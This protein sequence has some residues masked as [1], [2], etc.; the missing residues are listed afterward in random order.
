MGHRGRSGRAAIAGKCGGVYRPGLSAKSARGAQAIA[1]RF[2]INSPSPLRQPSSR[3]VPAPSL[4]R[5]AVL[6]STP[7]PPVPAPVRR[8]D[9][10]ETV[11]PDDYLPSPIPATPLLPATVSDFA[12]LAIRDPSKHAHE[13]NPFIITY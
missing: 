7:P 10:R 9:A 5:P 1:G 3:H 4:A 12:S 6:L 13:L 8:T 11:A 2:H